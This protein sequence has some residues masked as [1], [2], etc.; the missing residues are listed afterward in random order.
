MFLLDTLSHVTPPLLLFWLDTVKSRC[1]TPISWFDLESQ[2]RS[3]PPD[4]NVWNTIYYRLSGICLRALF[5][6]SIYTTRQHLTKLET[7]QRQLHD[8]SL[9]DRG[10]AFTQRWLNMRYTRSFHWCIIQMQYTHIFLSLL[11]FQYPSHEVYHTHFTRTSRPN[12][13][14]AVFLLTS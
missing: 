12:T 8:D 14:L 1:L 2:L 9:S 11:P 10:Y 6:F 4:W 7:F 3:N 5:F 13:N